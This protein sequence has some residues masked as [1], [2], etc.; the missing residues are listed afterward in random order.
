MADQSATVTPKLTKPEALALLNA[1]ET[2][3]AVIKALGLVKNTGLT[4][5]TAVARHRG[6]A[7]RTLNNSRSRRHHPAEAGRSAQVGLK[8]WLLQIAPAVV[9]LKPLDR[10]SIWKSVKTI[11]CILSRTYSRPRRPRSLFLRKLR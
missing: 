6:R 3:L 7:L 8:E 1:A 10:Q 5:E 9:N 4:E 2:G 11:R